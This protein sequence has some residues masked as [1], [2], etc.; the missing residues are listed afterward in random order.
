MPI[1]VPQPKTGWYDAARDEQ[2]STRVPGVSLY[3]V[4]MNS[5]DWDPATTLVLNNTAWTDPPAGTFGYAATYYSDYR[6]RRR[7]SENVSL[8]RRFRFGERVSLQIRMELANIFNR[9]Y[10]RDPAA[11]NALATTTTDSNG[12]LT[13]GF[14]YIDTAGTPPAPTRAGTL[15]AR[16]MF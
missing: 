10:Y 15:V 9:T 12:K 11:T 8:Q 6:Q 7:P 1:R 13:G 4:D 16:V 5:N 14:G 2:H 3:S